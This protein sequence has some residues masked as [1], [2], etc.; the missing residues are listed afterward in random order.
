[1]VHAAAFAAL[2]PVNLW[3]VDDSCAPVDPII[4]DFNFGD[5]LS[6]ELD[7]TMVN[8]GLDIG[9]DDTVDA[10]FKIPDAGITDDIVTLYA[11]HTD[12]LVPSLVAH[13]PSGDN[14]EI[15]PEG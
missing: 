6:V 9:Q 2:S 4:T 14:A 12:S 11:V 10:C 8:V 5:T 3:A 15:N 13:L 1:M 7:S